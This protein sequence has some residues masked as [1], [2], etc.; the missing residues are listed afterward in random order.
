MKQM[1]SGYFGGQS[2]H[3][4]R[5]SCILFRGVVF[6]VSSDCYCILFYHLPQGPRFH[7]SSVFIYLPRYHTFRAF[8]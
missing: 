2:F 1:S 5:V 3:L 4:G 6:Y 7:L 8:I